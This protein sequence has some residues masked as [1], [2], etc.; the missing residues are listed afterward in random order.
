MLSPGSNITSFTFYN[1]LWPIYWLSLPTIRAAG[2]L[3]SRA[4]C[5]GNS[6][7]AREK[8]SATAIPTEIP[9]FLVTVTDLWHSI[10]SLSEKSAHILNFSVGK[11]SRTRRVQFS[12]H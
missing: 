1:H 10:Y 5:P 7:G 2:R 11:I 4:H 12:P 9:T 3:A 8:N 6:A